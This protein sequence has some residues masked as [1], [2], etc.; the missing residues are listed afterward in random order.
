MWIALAVL[1]L[2][3]VQMALADHRKH[4]PEPLSQEM[5]DYINNDAK[6]T[7]K[8]SIVCSCTLIRFPSR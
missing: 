5:I 2:A 6:T 7:W 1:S 4:G 8:V 3:F